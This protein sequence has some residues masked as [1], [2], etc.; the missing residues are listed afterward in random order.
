[1]VFGLTG[2][3]GM[4]K[5]T[6]AK[7]FEKEGFRVIDTDEIARALVEPGESALE[8][9]VQSFGSGILKA[10][11]HLDRQQLA[12]IVFTNESKRRELE[13]I[14]HPKIRNGWKAQS[15]QF[16]SKGL[17]LVV[18]PLLFETGAEE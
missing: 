4:G 6:C 12:R 17:V 8:E 9:I 5:S 7:F 3:V 13:R 10:D 18:I 16:E 11:G 14:L 1:M 15:A 2:G